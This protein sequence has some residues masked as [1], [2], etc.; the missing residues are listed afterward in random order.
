MSSVVDRCHSVGSRGSVKRAKTGPAGDRQA[1]K[2]AKD[3]AK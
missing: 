3:Y 2:I 1:V